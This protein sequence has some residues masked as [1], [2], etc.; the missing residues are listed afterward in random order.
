MHATGA[1]AL[2]GFV[3]RRS[4]HQ[5]EHA[6]Q[7]LQAIVTG[8]LRFVRAKAQVRAL[9]RLLQLGAHRRRQHG[10]DSG[11]FAVEHH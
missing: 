7:V 6:A 5:P 4:A 8:A 10:H 9:L 3:G 2:E 11:V 1:F